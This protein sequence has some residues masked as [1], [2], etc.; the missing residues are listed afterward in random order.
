MK[1]L[2]IWLLVPVR[3]SFRYLSATCLTSP[4]QISAVLFCLF[5]GVKLYF[6]KPPPL[7]DWAIYAWV[8]VSNTQPQQVCEHVSVFMF[9]CVNVLSGCSS[10]RSF[11]HTWFLAPLLAAQLGR[12]SQLQFQLHVV[13]SAFWASRA[14]RLQIC[15]KY[16]AHT[17]KNICTIRPPFVLSDKYLTGI[18]I[19]N[20]V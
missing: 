1:K 20:I 8:L 9:M 10:S 18:V 14:F 15:I 2:S 16:V 12:L 3:S 11:G 7:V 13:S 5:F 19:K 6:L 17:Y 4:S